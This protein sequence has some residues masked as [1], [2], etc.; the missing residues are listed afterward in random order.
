MSNTIFDKILAGD[1]PVDSVFEDEDVLAFNDV[2]PKA[3]VHVLV[4][5][6]KRA[7]RFSELSGRPIEE[8]GRFFAA[9]SRIAA[10]LDLD[11]NGYRVVINNGPDGGQEVE[12]LHAHI[13]GGRRLTW[14]PG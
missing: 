8:I 6:K 3:P 1:I 7:S 14:P 13:L 5:P 9:V 4:I 11:E 12:Y 10:L 2:N